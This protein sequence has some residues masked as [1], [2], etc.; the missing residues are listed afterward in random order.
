M[1]W[2][3]KSNW[4]HDARRLLRLRRCHRQDL[5]LKALRAVLIKLGLM[6]MWRIDPKQPCLN[7]CNN[8]KTYNFQK[9]CK[10]GAEKTCLTLFL[11]VSSA[12]DVID[13]GKYFYRLH[14]L[15]S[16]CLVCKFWL[17]VSQP[18]LFETIFLRPSPALNKEVSMLLIQ[19]N[20]YACP[21]NDA[22]M[23]AATATSYL[24]KFSK[25]QSMGP[26]AIVHLA[27]MEA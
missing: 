20:S 23:T 25:V 9:N 14:F 5:R 17:R 24:N 19:T 3:T 4:S 2:D 8:R 10:I 6:G 22:P 27:G 1:V 11:C 13:I 7:S 12:A 21:D 15:R 16:S 26:S 18:L